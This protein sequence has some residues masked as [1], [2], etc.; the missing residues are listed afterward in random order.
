[1]LST[2]TH[3]GMPKKKI[4]PG[5]DWIAL[6]LSL[7]RYYRDK[8]NLFISRT[9][10]HNPWSFP[11]LDDIFIN[12]TWPS[13]FD[14]KLEGTYGRGPL[15]TAACAS[16]A[17][18]VTLANDRIEKI[19]ERGLRLLWLSDPF[20][21]VVDYPEQKS[22]PYISGY[23]SVITVKSPL[24]R[25]SEDTEDWDE[26]LEKFTPP[27]RSTVFQKV[28]DWFTGQSTAGRHLDELILEASGVDL[29]KHAAPDNNDPYFG[30]GSNVAKQLHWAFDLDRRWSFDFDAPTEPSYIFFSFGTVPQPK[31]LEKLD[32]FT[33]YTLIPYSFTK[34]KVHGTIVYNWAS[35]DGKIKESFS[36]PSINMQFSYTVVET[37]GHWQLVRIRPNKRFFFKGAMIFGNPSLTVQAD[38]L[39]YHADV[40]VPGSLV[41]YG[42]LA[43]AGTSPGD[44]TLSTA[45]RAIAYRIRE[46]DLL[47]KGKI[48]SEA[49]IISHVQHETY[50][51][52]TNRILLSRRLL[53]TA[54]FLSVV[55]VVGLSG[56]FYI[57]PYLAAGKGYGIV[58]TSHLVNSFKGM[59]PNGLHSLKP[60]DVLELFVFKGK[61][62][63]NEFFSVVLEEACKFIFGLPALFTICSIEMYRANQ[64]GLAHYYVPTMLM[65]LF[66]YVLTTTIHPTLGVIV[67]LVWNANPNAI[68]LDSQLHVTYG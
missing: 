12:L 24:N 15:V 4:K 14:D 29:D 68:E 64:H 5:S 27:N 62:G 52:R 38:E 11:Q 46:Y 7:P 63:E 18:A 22:A 10:S 67:H 30:K 26:F 50:H 17:A 61:L 55:S 42:T 48:A 41:D 31:H 6:A 39:I 33:I 16:H 53:H 51:A 43:V 2:A 54:K 60:Y 8:T 13:S 47:D 44:E 34:Q 37:L 35:T 49:S 1:M 40:D 19:S 59:T 9:P 65:H 36:V 21:T 28:K 66:T 25:R 32:C 23:T 20:R 56:Y 57:Q 45:H 58:L 3:L